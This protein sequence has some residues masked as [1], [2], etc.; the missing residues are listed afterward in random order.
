MSDLTELKRL[1]K[2][3]IEN[4]PHEWQFKDYKDDGVIVDMGF[5][6]CTQDAVDTAADSSCLTEPLG[7]F[8]AAANPAAVLELVERLEKADAEILKMR[9]YIDD[10]MGNDLHE[11]GHNEQTR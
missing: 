4:C 10:A 1:A 2:A 11:R 8:I 6:S 5:M 7:K 9:E 3:A